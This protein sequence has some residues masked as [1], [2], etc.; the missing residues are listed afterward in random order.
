LRDAPAAA[1]TRDAVDETG[2]QIVLGGAAVAFGVPFPYIESFSWRDDAYL[3]NGKLV[4]SSAWDV[5]AGG[6]ISIRSRHHPSNGKSA[7]LWFGRLL[8]GDDYRW[9]EVSYLDPE[10]PSRSRETLFGVRQ[11]LNVDKRS[12]FGDANGVFSYDVREMQYLVAEDPRPITHDFVQDFLDRWIEAFTIIALG[13]GP[14]LQALFPPE[15]ARRP[16]S[17]IFNLD[18]PQARPVGTAS[19]NQW[20]GRAW[21]PLDSPLTRH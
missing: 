17:P 1:V 16:V 9:W 6:Y 13:D 21:P 12:L 5:L 14:A 8:A 10:S 3:P 19:L 7:N 11:G 4:G 2:R 20:S 18:K 15:V